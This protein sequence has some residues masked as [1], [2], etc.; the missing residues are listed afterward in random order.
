LA[1]PALPIL[2]LEFKVFKEWET[3]KHG[4]K[5]SAQFF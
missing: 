2:L 4:S 5:V 3:S 1:R